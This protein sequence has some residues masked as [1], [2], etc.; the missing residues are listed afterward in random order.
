MK[1]KMMMA[2]RWF[3][4]WC[5]ITAVVAGVLFGAYLYG[6]FTAPNM[7]ANNTIVQ[8]AE[9]KIAP[10]MERIFKAESGGHQLNPK[11]GQLLIAVNK[12]GTVDV[13]IA[14]INSIW[15]ATATKLGYDLSKE[16]DNK[17]F[18]LYLYENY[19]TEPWGSS[20]KNW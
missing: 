19:G 6:Q 14:Q 4:K 17:K 16:E 10:V 3:I 7:T 15:F 2:V 9:N 5:A 18:A 13:G 11:T 8:A 1:Y 12:N 20:A